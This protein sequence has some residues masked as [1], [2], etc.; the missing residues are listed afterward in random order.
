MFINRNTNQSL[1]DQFIF[2][3]MYTRMK[4]KQ[5]SI[6]RSA[7]ALNPYLIFSYIRSEND[8]SLYNIENVRLIQLK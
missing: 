4:R 7:C 6:N 5:M 2:V 3:L 1:W 8:L